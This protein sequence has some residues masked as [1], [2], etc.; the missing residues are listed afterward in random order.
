MQIGDTATIITGLACSKTGIDLLKATYGNKGVECTLTDGSVERLQQSTL[1]YRPVL[2]KTEAIVYTQKCQ[3][4]QPC[5]DTERATES[6]ECTCSS[7]VYIR[8]DVIRVGLDDHSSNDSD[9][10]SNSR[11]RQWRGPLESN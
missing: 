5:L 1:T 9:S 6:D 2:P 3:A 8:M 11:L 4:K 7:S 10:N